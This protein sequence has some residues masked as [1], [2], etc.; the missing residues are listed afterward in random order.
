MESDRDLDHERTELREDEKKLQ[1]AL[2][3]YDEA[4]DYASEEEDDEEDRFVIDLEYEGSEAARQS[5]HS[6]ASSVG[7]TSHS[8]RQSAIAE[9]DESSETRDVIRNLP[10]SSSLD[11]HGLASSTT[12]VADPEKTLALNRAL[13]GILEGHIESINEALDHN[14]ERQER[15]EEEVTNPT[16]TGKCKGG[17]FRAPY[18]RADSEYPEPN[19]DVLAK[20]QMG[21]ARLAGPLGTGKDLRYFPSRA[22]NTLK[23]CVMEDCLEQ[24]IRPLMSKME[25]EIERCDQAKSSVE[26]QECQLELERPKLETT[27]DPKA[28][29]D[30]KFLI[31]EL[32]EGIKE[33][34]VKVKEHAKKVSKLEEEIKSLK[35]N[36]DEKELL[37]SVDS[38]KVDW[39]R[40]S[41]MNYGGN[42]SY[43]DCQ[44]AWD[45]FVCP[46]VKTGPWTPDEKARLKELTV[47]ANSAS[48]PQVDWA[49]VAQDL[50]V[51]I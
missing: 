51:S 2:Q 22:K 18:F 29:M 37:N 43:I 31:A 40:I 20:S 14:R 47:N 21:H 44:K 42:K 32:E 13:Q 16:K 27:T 48:D 49:Q 4:W 19:E 5:A 39:M 30:L 25:A 41:K 28:R 6:A 26:E 11:D 23:K 45:H 9:D 46:K 15:L 10:S 1:K 50:G 17:P 7:S 35:K 24:M 34:R 8:V 38:E 3:E 36:K 33:Q 12:G